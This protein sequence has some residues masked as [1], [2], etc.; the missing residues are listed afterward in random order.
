MKAMMSGTDGTT[1]RDQTRA[2]V[3]RPAST[4]TVGLAPTTRAGAGRFGR[5]VARWGWQPGPQRM[6]H[7]PQGARPRGTTAAALALLFLGSLAVPAQA[8]TLVSNIGQSNNTSA[9]VGSSYDYSKGSRPAPA[10]KR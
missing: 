10:E 2:P 3:T 8:A 6:D 7:A 5:A 1:R 4:P 9:S